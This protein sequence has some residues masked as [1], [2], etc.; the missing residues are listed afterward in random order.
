[1]SY[2]I[3]FYLSG[4]D[5]EHDPYYFREDSNGGVMF[6]Y[7]RILNNSTEYYILFLWIQR[8]DEATN[9]TMKAIYANANIENLIAEKV[10]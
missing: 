8:I 10:E 3:A 6:C 5:E 7:S 9:P 1:M 4:G 2:D